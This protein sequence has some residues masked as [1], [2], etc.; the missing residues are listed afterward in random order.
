MTSIPF[1]WYATYPSTA[2][3][4]EVV[5][6]NVIFRKFRLQLKNIFLENI[7]SFSCRGCQTLSS[8]MRIIILLLIMKKEQ[9]FFVQMQIFS[10]IRSKIF[11]K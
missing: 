11:E 1:T 2:N 9:A 5:S 7:A 6:K 4:T 8:D 10:K 3:N